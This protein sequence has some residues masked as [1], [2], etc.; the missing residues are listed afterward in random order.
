MRSRTS[1]AKYFNR[2]ASIVLTALF[3]V[4][5]F[6]GCGTDDGKST[7]RERTVLA[8]RN[9]EF[10][11][12]TDSAETNGSKVLIVSGL[13]G[14]M[15]GLSGAV[16]NLLMESPIAGRITHVPR[17]NV[18]AIRLG[19]RAPGGDMNTMFGPS[20]APAYRDVVTAL[21]LMADSSD[22]L[23][24]VTDQTEDVGHTVFYGAEAPATT[25]KLAQDIA[26][27]INAALP[28]LRR[29][30]GIDYDDIY[31][32][33]SGST[34]SFT[35]WASRRSKPSLAL[36][37]ALFGGRDG[38]PPR[39]E[40]TA[41]TQIC[42]VA[43][44]VELGALEEQAIARAL[45]SV[46][47]SPME[48]PPEPTT[49]AFPDGSGLRYLLD[50]AARLH[51]P[52]ELLSLPFNAVL[53]LEGFAG[54]RFDGVTV[55]I[56]GV[57]DEDD[58]GEEVSLDDLHSSDYLL[59]FN[60]RRDT[61]VV[62]SEI[63]MVGEGAEEPFVLQDSLGS[64]PWISSF[65]AP[66]T[67]L[68][69][70]TATSD[71]GVTPHVAS[72]IP[73]T[74]QLVRETD[75]SVHGSDAL[76]R[77]YRLVINDITIGRMFSTKWTAGAEMANDADLVDII[78]LGTERGLNP[79][80]AV[81][82]RYATTDNFLDADVY[83]G[84]NRCLLSRNVAE[85]LIRVQKNLLKRGL[86]LKVYDCLRPHAVQYRMWELRPEP[87]YVAPPEPGSNHNRGAAVDLTLVD[88]RG[89][90]LGMP[91][92]FDSFTE[93]AWHDAV[94]GLSPSQ[95]ENRVLLR[96][97]MRFEGFSSIRKE[98]WH[99]NGPEYRSFTR[100]LDVNLGAGYG[101]MQFPHEWRQ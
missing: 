69:L 97:E 68:Y 93:R 53:R 67:W 58:V 26:D 84:M 86:G 82:M 28:E 12:Y 38:S 31:A 89:V 72:N 91:T 3:A 61:T 48:A 80:I 44:M 14:D 73:N 100:N 6:N 74:V 75:R 10:T 37:F 20:T 41:F 39:G 29:T 64:N 92:E 17:A 52:G 40:Q 96:N 76:I 66:E 70:N 62:W 4:A 11:V 49:L 35:A 94:E 57:G 2:A 5:S 95:I 63:V 24:V 87:G 45:E 8:G 7:Y 54:Q 51:I 60:Y 47:G 101:R 22:A 59:E 81:D 16:D 85:A 23:L 65:P 32:L 50:G 79:G 36:E 34:G 18:N 15:P 21:Q 77:L 25:A 78:D 98:W 46:S 43:A 55:D 99:Y 33:R 13:I 27:R 83:D 1:I 88:E 9:N 56:R 19:Q 90:E 30:T 71:D 42:L